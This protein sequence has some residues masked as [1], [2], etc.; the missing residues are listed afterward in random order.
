MHQ[1]NIKTYYAG[2]TL[3]AIGPNRVAGYLVCFGDPT[4][5][6]LVGDY[7]D[8][9]TD[10]YDLEDGDQVLTLW[11]HN[12]DPEV[13]GPIGKGVLSR[14]KDGIWLEAQ[15]SAREEYAA[16]VADIMALVA[17]GKCGLSSGTTNHLCRKEEV[18]PGRVWHIKAWQIA[19]ASLTVSPAEPRTYTVPVKSEP[20]R[21]F[22]DHCDET[23]KTLDS[24]LTRLEGY[25][26]VKAKDNR[27]A[28]KDRH[29]QFKA[30]ASRLDAV[31][32]QT[33]PKPD[34]KLVALK[35]ALMKS[36]LQK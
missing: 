12:L 23:I 10:F 18:I 25:A 32:K 24:F 20:G 2:S 15:L 14:K 30:I 5:T 28:S 19:E 22:A 27:K 21:T 11:H 1:S 33:A 31:I 4:K 8:E 35:I 6:D 9:T 16:R 17:D 34:P 26:E 13:Q 7:F 3:K 29:E 36:K